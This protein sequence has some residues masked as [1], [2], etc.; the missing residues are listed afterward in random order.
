LTLDSV[1]YAGSIKPYDFTSFDYN[2]ENLGLVQISYIPPL[3]TSVPA[4]HSSGGILAELFF[5]VSS[6]ANP[7]FIPL[8]SVNIDSVFFFGG[9]EKHLWIR[10]AMSDSTGSLSHYP[11]CIPGGVEVRSPTDVTSGDGTA[12][13]TEFALSQNYP[14]P[15]NPS[16]KISYA[17][18]KAGHVK[19]EVFNI[20]GQSAAMLVDRRMPVGV[21]E[22]EFDAAAFPSGIYFYRLTQGGFSETK[23][24]ALVK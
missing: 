2:F 17:L 9:V 14:N 21:H 8:D 7:T 3:G 23:K 4:I 13:P 18:P 20:L 10:V 6:S 5:T 15:F 12:L 24:M 1:S 22:V 19:L 11:D 16:T